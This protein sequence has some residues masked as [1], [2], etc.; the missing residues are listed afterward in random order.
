MPLCSM[1]H[2]VVSESAHPGHPS[3][4]PRNSIAAPLTRSFHLARRDSDNLFF[5]LS[6]S[7]QVPRRGSGESP[8]WLCFAYCRGQ[9]TKPQ[10]RPALNPTHPPLWRGLGWGAS[11]ARR[12]AT[13][14]GWQ[15]S[16][17]RGLPNGLHNILSREQVVASQPQ[18]SPT[19]PSTTQRQ[20]ER[21]EQR[22][23]SCGGGLASPRRP[24]ATIVPVPAGPRRTLQLQ[25]WSGTS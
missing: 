16:P 4:W 22:T 15:P 6:T 25:I 14:Q 11:R 24:A 18:S 20:G 10:E 3:P 13:A 2:R 1:R 12:G 17:G 19:L 5:P 8:Q 23:R 7:L 21:G 9:T